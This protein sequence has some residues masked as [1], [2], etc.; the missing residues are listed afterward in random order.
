MATTETKKLFIEDDEIPWEVTAPGIRRKIM[1]WDER[2]MMVKVAFEK[3]AVGTLHRHPHTQISHVESGVFEVEACGETKILKA[4]DAFYI[5]P[6]AM[7]GAIC[8][9]AGM[10]I[11]VF[12]PMR[13]DFISKD[14]QSNGTK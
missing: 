14:H 12:S 9:E 13:E 1:S 6:N 10:L 4:G 2:L 3:G 7:H 5:P 11:D 8:L